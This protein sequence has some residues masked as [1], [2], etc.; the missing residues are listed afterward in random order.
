MQT[1]RKKAILILG[2]TGVGKTPLGEICEKNRLWDKN[3]FHFD[4]GETLRTAASGKKFG[5]LLNS[6]DIT[7]IKKVLNEGALLEN[8]TFYIAERVLL[9]F[10]AEKNIKDEDILLINGLPRHR[11]QANDVNKIIHITNL[12]HLSATPEVI[13]ER[14]RLNTGGDRAQ[15]DDDSLTEIKNKLEI[16]NSRTLPLIEYFK[17]EN[18][19]I[20]TY[21]VEVHTTAANLYDQINMTG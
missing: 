9:S 6:D 15:R 21:P 14:I 12:I 20:W 19:K 1:K 8:E 5:K 13:V 7:F 10:I 11:D 3:C 18:A 16:F 4:F 2:P 17:D